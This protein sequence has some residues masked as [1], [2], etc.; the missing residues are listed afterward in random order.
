MYSRLK[1]I[2][3]GDDF[4]ANSADIRRQLAHELRQIAV[5]V[6][7]GNDNSVCAQ[8]VDDMSNAV[9]GRV[10]LDIGEASKLS[11]EPPA[12]PARHPST[13]IGE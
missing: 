5:R 3:E 13:N 6:E 2:L 11:A 10:M 7:T 8:I 4:G 12:V 9:I 1:V